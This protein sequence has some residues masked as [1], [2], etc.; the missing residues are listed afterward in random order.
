MITLL[1]KFKKSLIV[2]LEWV[3]ILLFAALVVDVLWGVLSRASGGL[4]L[5]E[6]RATHLYGIFGGAAYFAPI[7]GG[8]AAD[9]LK[10]EK[11]PITIGALLLSAGYFVL[12]LPPGQGLGLLYLAITTIAVSTRVPEASPNQPLA[13][14][15]LTTNNKPRSASVRAASTNHC[16]SRACPREIRLAATKNAVAPQATV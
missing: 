7:F 14:G 9:A 5:P 13:S 6:K 4:S 2:L 12:A 16:R 1:M 15:R 3:I 8:A 10:G 11:W